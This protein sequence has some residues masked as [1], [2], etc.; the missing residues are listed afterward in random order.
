MAVY[1][2]GYRRYRGALTAGWSRFLVL[3]KYA[4]KDVFRSRLLVGFY[5]LC[6]V[7]P[8]FF[9]SIVYIRHNAPLLETLQLEVSDILTIDASFFDFLLEVQG[10]FA[11][12]LA[13]F[14][15]PGLVSRDLY[16]N[17]LP[18]YLCR[19]ISRVDY[20]L[21]KMTV[22]VV[23]LS[24]ITWIPGLILFVLQSN[25]AGWSWAVENW[26]IGVGVFVGSMLWVA[27]LGTTA[28]ALSA[29]L[30]WRVVAAFLMLMIFLSGT[31]VGNLSSF[32]FQNDWGHLA[33]PGRL[34]DIV[35]AGLFGTSA[36][37]GPPLWAAF[38]AL[39]VLAAVFWSLLHRRVRAYEV[40]S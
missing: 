29:W 15:G 38:F 13:L 4:M 21:G 19:P 17:G 9:L 18:L 1:E 37:A 3:P 2:R 5:A 30:R 7:A 35:L 26:R 34:M 33:N 27:L 28:L 32:L 24:S 10:R 22:L 12:F 40:V 25:L 31:V 16:N 20:I 11:F 8:L 36:P 6:F 23:L 39:T 14:V